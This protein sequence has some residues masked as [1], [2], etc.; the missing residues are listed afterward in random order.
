VVIQCRFSGLWWRYWGGRHR[1]KEVRFDPKN[2]SQRRTFG[3]GEVGSV[4]CVFGEVCSIQLGHA[5]QTDYQT[6]PLQPFSFNMKKIPLVLIGR[7]GSFSK[8]P[9]EGI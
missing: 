9:S 7:A 5:H 8:L 3:G 4:L 6:Q 1:P 2:L